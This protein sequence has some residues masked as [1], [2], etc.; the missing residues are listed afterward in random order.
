MIF[1]HLN[2]FTDDQWWS[3]ELLIFI[4]PSCSALESC[5]SIKE[6][7]S[8]SH[9]WIRNFCIINKPIEVNIEILVNFKHLYNTVWN[10]STPSLV[11]QEQIRDK[12]TLHLC[13]HE[14]MINPSNFIITIFFRV[15][16]NV[17]H[18]NALIHFSDFKMCMC[19]YLSA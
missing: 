19:I 2:P 16:N 15:W 6:Y 14:I 11:A 17:I 4:V 1:A 8:R 7:W 18:T 9:R 12:W 10:L 5:L 3:H 13:Y